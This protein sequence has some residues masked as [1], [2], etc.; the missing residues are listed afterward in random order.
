MQKASELGQKGR[1][2]V[3]KNRSY[4]ILA[5]QLEKRY[6]ELGQGKVVFGYGGL[7]LTS[8]KE[9]SELL[10]PVTL[11]PEGFM[12]LMCRLCVRISYCINLLK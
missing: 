8:K 6:L 7:T 5:Q 12:P 2:W 4:K 3:R 9:W 1:K 11:G 10:R